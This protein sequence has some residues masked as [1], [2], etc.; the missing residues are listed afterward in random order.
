MNAVIFD[1]DG[2][3]LQSD[4]NDDAL[5][6]AAVRDV[7]GNIKLRPDWSMYTQFTAS[8]ILTEILNDNAITATINTVLAVQDQ[9]VASVR[10]HISDHGPFAEIPGSTLYQLCLM[11]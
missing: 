7:L 1:I 8:G 9:F 11:L 2:T 6:L 3:L 10:R 5:Y 4:A